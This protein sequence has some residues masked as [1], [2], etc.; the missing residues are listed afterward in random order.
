MGRAKRHLVPFARLP[1]SG[2]FTD[3]DELSR[4]GM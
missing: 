3:W 1:E 2:P 4:I